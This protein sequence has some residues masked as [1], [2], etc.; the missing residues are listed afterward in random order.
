MEDKG[1]LRLRCIG[2]IPVAF[3]GVLI[4]LSAG[5]G[6][7]GRTGSLNSPGRIAV[8]ISADSNYDSENVYLIN[9]DGSGSKNLVADGVTGD[10]VWSPT[11]KYLALARVVS[12]GILSVDVVR[13]D[14]SFAES[15]GTVSA[16]TPPD[17]QV[18]A[19]L[20]WSPD[21]TR[22]LTRSRGGYQILNVSTGN[23]R[24]V[25]LPPDGAVDAAWSPDGT[26]IAYLSTSGTVTVMRADDDSGAAVIATIKPP[27][28]LTWIPKLSWCPGAHGGRLLAA[29]GR[30]IYLVNGDGTGSPTQVAP[31]Q[32]NMVTQW[33]ASLDGRSIAALDGNPFPVPPTP[34]GSAGSQGCDLD[35]AS[36]DGSSP[37]QQVTKT[38]A[39][40]DTVVPTPTWSSDGTHFAVPVPQDGVLAEVNATTGAV[41]R[42]SPLPTGL[43]GHIAYADWQPTPANS[44]G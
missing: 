16:F 4:A 38:L 14:G 7:G 9:S 23:H 27:T 35:V 11:G 20:H 5:C 30:G 24:T 13:A 21:G 41:V 3:S 43:T 2:F 37:V 31:T 28:P 36:V 8:T 42:I 1:K 26:R 19:E 34:D 15:L 10:P 32:L 6:S 12:H 22:L 39:W 18:G 40:D 25:A 33:A 29:V 17:P 44:G